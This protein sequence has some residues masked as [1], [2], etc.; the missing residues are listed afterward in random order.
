[1]LQNC[2]LDALQQH[3]GP[4]LQL[5][6]APRK[7]MN[8]EPQLLLH[9]QLTQLLNKVLLGKEN[10]SASESCTMQEQNTQ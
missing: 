3:P 9:S 7:L 5:I 2:F 6:T 8:Q 1:M 10:R 4:G